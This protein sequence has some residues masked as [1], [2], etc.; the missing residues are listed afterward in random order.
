M[1]LPPR[2]AAASRILGSINGHLAVSRGRVESVSAATESA[3]RAGTCSR[4]DPRSPSRSGRNAPEELASIDAL[5]PGVR[6]GPEPADVTL[7]S[8]GR[9]IP[10]A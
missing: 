2:V 9:P 5:D 10:E 6:G 7:E 3:A 8:Y 4:G 1:Y